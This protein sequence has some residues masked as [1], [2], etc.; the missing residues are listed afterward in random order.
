MGS[1]LNIRLLDP[2]NNL[3]LSKRLDD[4]LFK[5]HDLEEPCPADA[6][7]ESSSR[8][9]LVSRSFVHFRSV[10]GSVATKLP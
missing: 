8:I 6:V 2:V 1:N 4:F 10:C 5:W 3:I 9:R 7:S